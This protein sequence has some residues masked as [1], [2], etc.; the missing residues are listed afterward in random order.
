MAPPET[1][2]R[3]KLDLN[4]RAV[5]LT[6]AG[7]AGFLLLSLAGLWV[8]WQAGNGPRSVPLPRAYGPPALQSDP[9]GD[10]RDHLKAQ[11]AARDSYA[12]ADRER[13]LVRIPVSRAME[14]LAGRGEAAWAPLG[15]TPSAAEAARR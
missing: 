9:A 1:Q 8:F 6:A 11:Q 14:I 2:R 10:L 13:G 5:V 15:P 3:E 12:W 7:T 4:L